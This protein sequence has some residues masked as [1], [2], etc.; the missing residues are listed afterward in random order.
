MHD[1][2]FLPI[3]QLIKPRKMRWAGHIA[4]MWGGGEG[5]KRVL[6]GKTR[7]KRT[8]RKNKGRGG[9]KRGL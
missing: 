9:I 1:V 6:G 5:G 7:K 8:Q 2:Y 3:I 4:H